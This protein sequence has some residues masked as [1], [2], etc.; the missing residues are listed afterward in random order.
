MR[1]VLFEDWLTERKLDVIFYFFYAFD[2]VIPRQRKKKKDHK[3]KRSGD[4]SIN[5]DHSPTFVRRA[6]NVNVLQK[7][8]K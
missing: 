2:S 6:Q 7:K 3:R 8:K 4:L 1:G 5:Y